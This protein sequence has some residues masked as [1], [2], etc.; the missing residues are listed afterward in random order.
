MRSLI[1][2]VDCVTELDEA[3]VTAAPRPAFVM[4]YPT[5]CK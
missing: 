3:C 5:E 2:C 4:P 1:A